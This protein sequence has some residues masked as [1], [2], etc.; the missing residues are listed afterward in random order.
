M[1]SSKSAVGTQPTTTYVWRSCPKRT[2]ASAMLRL[3]WTSHQSL[4]NSCLYL[5]DR[6]LRFASS[7]EI[8]CFAASIA[9]RID[10]VISAGVPSNSSGRLKGLRYALLAARSMIS[11]LLRGP[12]S[13]TTGFCVSSLSVKKTCGTLERLVSSLFTFAAG[14]TPR[15][16]CKKF[17]LR[18][19][20]T[21]RL[22]SAMGSS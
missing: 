22:I 1:S 14:R 10:P 17:D 16:E 20:L 15:M 21:S 6:F 12:S 4:F 19:E 8:F 9:L 13:H 7:S 11:E 18:K 3:T 2:I 5:P